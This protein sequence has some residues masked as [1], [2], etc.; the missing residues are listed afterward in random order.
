MT[1][2]VAGCNDNGGSDPTPMPDSP[3]PGGDQ[4]LGGITDVSNGNTISIAF[5][6]DRTS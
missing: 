1:F 4:L 2:L 5:L 6:A 3:S